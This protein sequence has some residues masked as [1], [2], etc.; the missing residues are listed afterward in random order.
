[1]DFIRQIRDF[2]SNFQSTCISRDCR[3]IVARL[4]HD[5]P[6]NVALVSFS[7]VRQSTIARLSYDSR[8]SF[9]RL[10]HDD[11]TNVALVSFSFVRQSRDIRES[12]SRHSYECRLVLFFSPD[13][14]EDC[15][16]IIVRHS[17]DN[18]TRVARRSCECREHV[19]AKFWRIYNSKISRLSYDCRTNAVR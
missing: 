12:V 19:A 11:P 13:S 3:A 10:S 4:S 2:R 15:R 18:R 1:M 9:V 6:T 7:F 14:R 5:V 17:Y 8:E 16:A